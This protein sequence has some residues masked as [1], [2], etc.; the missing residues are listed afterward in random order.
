MLMKEDL[1][2]YNTAKITVR[3]MG[4]RTDGEMARSA[5]A[6]V[7]TVL[8]MFTKLLKT[9]FFILAITGTIVLLSVLSVIWSFRDERMG[10]LRSF[11]VAENSMVYVADTLHI[12]SVDTAHWTQHM[13]YSG[14]EI[15]TSV[16]FS[17]IPKIMQDAMTAI[18]DKRFWT[19]EGVDWIG[20]GRAVLGLALGADETVGGSTITQQLI[21]NVTGENQVSIMRKIKEIFM[22]LNLEKEYSKEEIL[23]AYLNR[24]NFGNG[25]Y[26]VQAAAK[27]YFGK[28]IWDCNIAECATIAATTQNPSQLCVFYY[29]EANKRRRD[30]VIDEMWN[31]GLITRAEYEQAQYDSDHLKTRA[32]EDYVPPETTED[33]QTQQNSVNQVWNEYDEEVFDDTIKLLMKYGNYSEENA[34]DLIYNGGLKIYSAQ[35]VPLQEG[36]EDLLEN[37]WQEYTSESDWDIWTGACLMEY[38]GRILCV[39]GNKGVG[40]GT[41]IEKKENLGWNIV[42]DTTR[43]PGSSIKPI[44]VY[45]EAL[46]E[47]AITWG[48]VLKDEPV[49]NYFGVGDLTPGPSNFDGVYAGTASVDYAIAKSLNAPP[50]N[51]LNQIGVLTSYRF[52]TE[53]LH[54]TS[55][56][57]GDSYNLGGLSIGGLEKGVSVR[58]MVGAYQI[59]GNGGVYNE[60]YTVYRIEDH[61]GNVIYDYQLSRVPEQACSP[62]NAT[63]MNKLLHEPL[64]NLS[65]GT[66]QMC[67]REDLDQ[68]AKTGTAEDFMD[69]W[70]MGGTQSFIAGIWY[71]HEETSEVHDTNGAKKMYNGIIDWLE[72][73]YSDFLHSGSFVLSPNVVQM[74]YCRDSGLR[75]GSNC[76]ADHI[77]M[78]WFNQNDLPRTCNGE[79]DHIAVNSANASPSPT[80]RP[81]NPQFGSGGSTNPWGGWTGTYRPTVTAPPSYGGGSYGGSSYGQ[82]TQAPAQGTTR[83]ADQSSSLPEHDPF[84]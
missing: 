1:N 12:D 17:Q 8:G 25:Y 52:M 7:H 62:E 41:L 39:N 13:R 26:G 72:E 34:I 29:P 57:E 73:N 43:P 84:S 70:Y 36:F 30:T 23:E 42:S 54:F 20:T 59:F 69:I 21:K 50:A 5:G 83:S 60:P 2:R 53:K 46:E 27:G 24:V 33:E 4:G 15:R 66:A 22:A 47:K 28:N 61:E 14:G 55:L 65:V 64:T 82:A 58:Q 44:G 32:D 81:V 19:H 48:S 3:G 49:P 51:L 75:P 40:D 18:E 68:I 71:G 79:S 9:V 77:A 31:Q 38:D 63:I 11:G 74:S 35:Y 67:Y 16:P 80:P 78:G 45:I 6:T 76:A 10:N 56:T 37:H